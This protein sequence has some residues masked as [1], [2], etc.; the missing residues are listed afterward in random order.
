MMSKINK[1]SSMNYNDIK[2]Y[3]EACP[4]LAGIGPVSAENLFWRAENQTL[5]EGEVLFRQGVKLEDTFGLLLSG[6]LALE[7]SGEP[8]GTLT[9]QQIGFGEMAY[10]SYFRIQNSTV[11]VN[12]PQAVILRF[13]MSPTDL[14]SRGFFTLPGCLSNLT[15]NRSKNPFP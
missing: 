12:S 1:S 13:R 5:K 9:R 2:R 6:E 3:L 10:F 4:G 8:I 7:R 11:R 15:L 14:G